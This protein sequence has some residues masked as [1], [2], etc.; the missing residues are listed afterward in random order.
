MK[1]LDTLI[2]I[3]YVIVNAFSIIQLIGS[4]RWPAIT[5]IVFFFIFGIAAFVNIQAVIDMP[6][7]Y[8]SYADYAIP[9][10]SWFILG[11]FEPIITPMVLAIATGQALIAMSMFMQRRWFRLGCLGGIIFCLAIAPLGL[12]AAFPS[13]LLLAFALYRLY[14]LENKEAVGQTTT[15]PRIPLPLD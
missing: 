1:K 3:A 5:R 7:V 15:R 8:Q 6:W 2:A 9:F 11:P 10:Y 13:T 12:G 4:Y 14:T